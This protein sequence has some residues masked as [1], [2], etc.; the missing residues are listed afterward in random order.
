V[1]QHRGRTST[2]KTRDIEATIDIGNI[3]FAYLFLAF[4][5]VRHLEEC[6]EDMNEYVA[7]NGIK[8]CPLFI[9]G[10]LYIFMGVIIAMSN[11]PGV[12]MESL[13][14]KED[15]PKVKKIGTTFNFSVVM[16]WT[17]FS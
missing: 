13:W 14:D 17:R 7:S 5:H 4:L 15:F 9:I 6:L 2:Y 11:F 8:D 3:K 1:Q 16:S 10:E 12:K